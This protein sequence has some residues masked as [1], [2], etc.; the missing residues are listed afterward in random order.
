MHRSSIV[1]CELQKTAEKI[2]E[3]LE[4]PPLAILQPNEIR[5]YSERCIPSWYHGIYFVQIKHLDAPEK[6]MGISP[7]NI[8]KP[9]FR[10]ALQISSRYK[11]FNALA[12]RKIKGDHR[13][14]SGR[15]VIWRLWW[16]EILEDW[17]SAK[18]KFDTNLTSS[19][20]SIICWG[21]VWGENRFLSNGDRNLQIGFRKQPSFVVKPAFPTYFPD[22]PLTVFNDK[23]R[24]WCRPKSLQQRRFSQWGSTTYFGFRNMEPWTP[25]VQQIFW[26]WNWNVDKVEVWV[27]HSE[28]LDI[29]FVEP[30]CSW[31]LNIPIVIVLYVIDWLRQLYRYY[32]VKMEAIWHTHLYTTRP[33]TIVGT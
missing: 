32:L 24:S 20:I 4:C 8:L 33:A 31:W 26:N 15:Y 6:G 9:N 28:L 19:R 25:A 10:F 14:V 3:W 7:R 18:R 23:S 11:A 13:S 30:S 27:L 1:H 16:D 5:M 2:K 29:L 22:L 12:F 17:K 21:H